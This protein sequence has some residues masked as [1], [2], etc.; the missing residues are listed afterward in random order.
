[1]SADQ[2]QRLID[3]VPGV[4]VI[5]E[6]TLPNTHQV[7]AV[8]EHVGERVEGVF[9]GAGGAYL[10]DELRRGA[11]G[12]M[13]APEFLELHVAIYDRFMAGDEAAATDVFN[14]LLPGVN[15]ERLLNVPFVKEVLY[16]RGVLRTT[17][18]RMSAAQ[19]DRHDLS[20]IDRLWATWEPYFRATTLSGAA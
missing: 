18:T 2:L 11:T 10:L 15:Y 7:G 6:E 12:C 8:V 1:M 4:R 9:G 17:V 5:K 19:L 13:P 14:V 16:R 20:E 3:Q